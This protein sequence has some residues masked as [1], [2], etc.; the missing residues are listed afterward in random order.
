[1]VD[2]AALRLDMSRRYNLGGMSQSGHSAGSKRTVRASKRT[3]QQIGAAVLTAKFRGFRSCG[4]LG[5]SFVVVS[6]DAAAA[7]NGSGFCASSVGCVALIP[8]EAL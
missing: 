4:T 8:A 2:A 1:M 7:P 3:Q 6:V 5:S